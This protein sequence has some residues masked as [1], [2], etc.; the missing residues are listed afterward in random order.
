MAADL[1]AP[2]PWDISPDDNVP[3]PAGIL[4]VTISR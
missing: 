1:Y 4:A 2:H 3:I